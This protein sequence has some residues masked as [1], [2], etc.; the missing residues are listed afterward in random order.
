[1]LEESKHSTTGQ[2]ADY[3]ID[4]LASFMSL[5]SLSAT[6]MPQEFS[7]FPYN[8][9]SRSRHLTH[10]NRASI[11]GRRLAH[12]PRNTGSTCPTPQ[13]AARLMDHRQRHAEARVSC[14]ANDWKITVYS[15]LGSTTLIAGEFPCTISERPMYYRERLGGYRSWERSHEGNVV[16]GLTDGILGS[17]TATVLGSDSFESFFFFFPCNYSVRVEI[18]VIM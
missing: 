17:D 7:V 6:T 10:F 9:E 2:T 3:E 14:C 5:S 13:R 12:Q 15:A 8:K 18:Y 16:S 11:S 4:V 1:M